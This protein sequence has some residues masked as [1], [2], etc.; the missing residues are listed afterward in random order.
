MCVCGMHSAPWL[1]FDGFDVLIASVFLFFPTC[2][3]F[4]HS[5]N[6]Y[7]HFIFHSRIPPCTWLYIWCYSISMTNWVWL[8][9]CNR[10]CLLIT[11]SQLQTT[12][13]AT[14]HATRY[15]RAAEHAL[16]AIVMF[17]TNTHTEHA[18]HYATSHCWSPIS[19][20]LTKT[21][22]TIRPHPIT[23]PAT[24]TW[25][26]LSFCCIYIST[27]AM[28]QNISTNSYI[29]LTVAFIFIF[30]LTTLLNNLPSINTHPFFRLNTFQFI[31]L[32][33]PISDRSKPGLL[34]G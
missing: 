2:C 30:Q 20:N 21:F 19:L 24:F 25:P 22:P 5:L 7:T 14:D 31:L 8:P 10:H 18:T 28:L 12:L 34:I 26:L 27:H 23:S 29:P 15:R 32:S 16:T 4:P 6:I 3:H 1:L 33:I 17:I 9:L 13:H 11:L